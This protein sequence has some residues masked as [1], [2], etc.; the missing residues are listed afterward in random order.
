M[1][2]ARDAVWEGVVTLAADAVVADAATLVIR[3][4]TRVVFPEG[5]GGP[6]SRWGRGG[7]VLLGTDGAL[8]LKVFGAV[9]ILGTPEAPVSFEGPGFGGILLSSQ[10]RLIARGARFAA[11]GS[12][13]VQCADLST[14]SFTDCSFSGGR[15]AV[16]CCGGARAA[17]RRVR[18]AGSAQSGFWICDD[19]VL[20]AAGC[21]LE[22]NAWALAA[23]GLARVVLRGCRLAGNRRGADITGGA[24]LRS[25]GS[26]WR[27]HE[28]S[29]STQI[30]SVV[31]LSGDR[32]TDNGTAVEALG[33]AVCAARSCRFERNAT[34]VRLQQRARFDGEDLD[35]LGNAVG[36][37][38]GDGARLNVA[39]ARI[40]GRPED[41][42]RRE[43]LAQARLEA[44]EY[45]S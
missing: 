43:D 22:D 41:G 45:A 9:E 14:A 1:M 15:G 27:G 25:A 17:A 33:D 31:E 21:V 18:C 39:R 42:I 3:A 12:F 34:A 4:G 26:E 29:V 7:R 11:S 20:R 10:A 6:L 5:S 24:R 16:F 8:H 32:F 19:A 28:T 40:S 36:L 30:E 37:H 2:I 13:A 38:A 23:E 44:I 35:L